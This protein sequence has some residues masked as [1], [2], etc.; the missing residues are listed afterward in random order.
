MKNRWLDHHNAIVQLSLRAV[1]QTAQLKEE[2]I[3]SKLLSAEK[4]ISLSLICIQ[5]DDFIL[6]FMA[7]LNQL[8]CLQF[9]FLMQSNSIF[10]K[11]KFPVKIINNKIFSWSKSRFVK[12]K[13]NKYCNVDGFKNVN[14]YLDFPYGR[15]SSFLCLCTTSS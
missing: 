4:V 5:L 3:Y 2:T 15:C 9:F 12:R 7:A 1:L 10:S 6:L 14:V 13:T 8:L 11:F